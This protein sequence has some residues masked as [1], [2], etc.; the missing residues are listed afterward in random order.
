MSCF[1]GPWKIFGFALS[2]FQLLTAASRVHSHCCQFHTPQNA[3]QRRERRALRFYH[4]VGPL[5]HPC[6]SHQLLLHADV[7]MDIPRRLLTI[8]AVVLLFFMSPAGCQ[9][10]SFPWP[11]CSLM[12]Q[13][14]EAALGCLGATPT[15][16]EGVLTDD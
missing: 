13:T 2:L 7:T 8:A 12:Q 6:V 5:C 1:S 14:P 4:T 10:F 9:G 3:K 11:R 16:G 15:Q